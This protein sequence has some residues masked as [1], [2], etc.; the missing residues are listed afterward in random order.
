M[1][2]ITN[3]AYK[4]LHN[5]CEALS[6][7]EANGIKIDTDYLNKAI[8][9]TSKQINEMSDR[10][11]QHK[12][13]KVWRKRYGSRTN[14]GS[15]EQLGRVLFD[16]MKYNCTSRTEKTQRPKADEEALKSTG[17]K[18]VDRYLRLEKLK[19]AK[20]TYL[21][22][23]LRETIDGF[24]HPNFPLHLVRSYRGSSDH[25]NFQNIPMKEPE[26]KKLVRRAFI[27]RKNHQIVELD[28]KR[29][30]VCSAACYNKDPQMIKYVTNPKL[31][32]HR[33]MG[34]KCY[35]VKKSQVSWG[36]RDCGKNRFVFAEFYGSWYKTRAISLWRGI[37]EMDLK[38]E[39]TGVNLYIH[40][41]SKGIHKLGA[42]NPDEEPEEGT[43]EKHIQEVEYDF[44]NRRF[45]VYNQWKKDWWEEYQ[46][47]GCFELLT[48]FVIEGKYNR[49]QIINYPIQGTAFHWLLWSLIKIQKLMTKYKMKSLIVGQIHD[50]IIGDIHKK[51]KKDYLEIA[52][53]VI[54][55]DIRKHWKWIIV[56]LR[57]EAGVAPIGG[58]WYDKKEVE[59]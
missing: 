1:K 8:H 40:L 25:P 23:I 11:K 59:M 7:V 50:S 47:K 21:Q 2:P 34:A 10:L 19:N 18:F 46:R 12:I 48:R 56:P 30:E 15:R 37:K 38:I 5:G 33:D 28:F 53:Q 42:C 55:E 45:K 16:V 44:W 36:I 13:Y 20:G 41:K 51:E 49:R 22:G 6:Q 17:L 32:M 43:F 52:K 27:A 54:Y 4:L 31:D 14:L 35:M 3:Q 58:S 57:V 26:I 39:E 29:A 24:T 9:K